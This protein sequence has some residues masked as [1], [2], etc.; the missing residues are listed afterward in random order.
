MPLSSIKMHRLFPL[1]GAR[2]IPA[3]LLDYP[4]IRENRKL[5]RSKCGSRLLYIAKRVSSFSITH[6]S[7]ICCAFSWS[8]PMHWLLRTHNSHPH[9]HTYPPMAAHNNYNSLF[10]VCHNPTTISSST[11]SNYCAL[12]GQISIIYN[13]VS[14]IFFYEVLITEVNRQLLFF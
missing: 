11:D 8:H 10:H 1:Q 9:K 14:I 3:Q 13:S 2:S 7:G 6:Q 4:F 12:L 5:T